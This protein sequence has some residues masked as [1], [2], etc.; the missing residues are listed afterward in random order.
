MRTLYYNTN[1]SQRPAK[2][3]SIK[4]YQRRIKVVSNIYIKVC[5][6]ILLIYFD[7]VWYAY[8]NHIKRYQTLFDMVW[9]GVSKGYQT[10][11]KFI[12]KRGGARNV[13]FSHSFCCSFDMGFDMISKTYQRLIWLWYCFDTT[14][15]RS[16][17]GH[18]PYQ[19]SF[20]YSYQSISNYIKAYQTYQTRFLI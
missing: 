15:G 14:R 9:Y 19:T 17:R 16:D 6:D 13:K 7:T 2:N 11:I 8:Q 4:L 5:F 3:T 12:S 1:I 20:W 18:G 10:H